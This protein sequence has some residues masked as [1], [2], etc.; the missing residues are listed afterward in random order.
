MHA[1]YLQMIGVITYGHAC[2]V[3][4]LTRPDL[5]SI[6]IRIIIIIFVYII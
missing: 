6:N 5:E 2:I 1:R 3:N 4:A